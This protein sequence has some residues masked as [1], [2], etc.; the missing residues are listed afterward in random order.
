MNSTMEKDIK[1]VL[2]SQEEIREKVAEVGAKI[3]DDY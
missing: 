2:L 1:R 3:A